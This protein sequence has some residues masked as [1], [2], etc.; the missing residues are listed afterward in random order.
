[1]FVHHVVVCCQ[2][3]NSKALAF[4][5]HS[6]TAPQRANWL[7]LQLQLGFLGDVESVTGNVC[8]WVGWEW[9]CH[10]SS[11]RNINERLHCDCQ[12]SVAR[13]VH[14]NR[15][16]LQSFPCCQSVLSTHKKEKSTILLLQRGQKNHVYHLI[17]RLFGSSTQQTTGSREHQFEVRIEYSRQQ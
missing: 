11:R 8:L 12:V 15:I 10:H 7:R 1:M 6:C 14:F 17:Q 2:L 13:C 4:S 16:S 5:T 3:Q 9:I